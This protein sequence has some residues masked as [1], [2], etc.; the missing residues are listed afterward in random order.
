MLTYAIQK[1]GYDYEQLDPQGSV[2]YDGFIHALERFPWAG[3]L[4]QWNDEQSGP[5]PALVL[6]D[7]EARRELWISALGTTLGDSFQLNAVSM[8]EKKGWFGMGKPKADREVVTF[9]VQAR[10]DVDRLCRLFCDGEYAQLDEDVA[11]L[12]E[13][14]REAEEERRRRRM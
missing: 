5:L 11:R 12:A 2:D 1:T 6:Q 7:A 14:S 9:E 10:G 13:R 4:A 3:Q 8:R